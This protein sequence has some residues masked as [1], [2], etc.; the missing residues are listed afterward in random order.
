MSITNDILDRT[1]R[2]EGA[3]AWM[4][5]DTADKVTVG[6]GHMLPD[7]AAA[8]AVGGWVDDGGNPA[9]DDQVKRDFE[10]VQG[11]TPG[12]VASH[13]R[14]LS[15]SRLPGSQID[16]L[17]TCDLTNVEQGL[18]A[19]PK[20]DG[21]DNYPAKA[22]A[23][24]IDMAFNLGLSGLLHKFPRFCQAVHDQ[25]W[26]GAAAECHRNGISEAR[27][28]EVKQLFLDAALG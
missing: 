13:Y 7:E 20:F 14:S 5:L 11:D 12:Q 9:G 16:N 27:N 18:Q 24:L 19:Q 3:I 6:V 23:G 8:V 4:Y 15:V 2:F 28:S 22:Q 17:L 25:N 10:A 21:Y 1:R 26:N